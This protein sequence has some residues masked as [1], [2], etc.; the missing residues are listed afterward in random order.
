[1]HAPTSLHWTAAKHVLCY[2]KGYVDSGL[3]YNQGF[4]D[5]TTFFDSDWTRK[6]M[7]EDPRLVLKFSS[8]P[9]DL[10]VSQETTY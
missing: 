8:P 5:L 9:T 1:M 4:V 2:L 10:L 3:Q 6:L 7:T